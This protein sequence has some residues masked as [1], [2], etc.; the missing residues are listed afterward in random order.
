MSVEK[1]P[2]DQLRSSKQKQ[3]SRIRPS[4][5]ENRQLDQEFKANIKRLEKIKRSSDT[6]G[7][8]NSKFTLKS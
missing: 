2:F 7:E 8:P 1:Q 3:S 5:Q 4:G 6:F